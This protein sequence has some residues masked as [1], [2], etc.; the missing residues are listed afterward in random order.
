MS[1]LKVPG[2]EHFTLFAFIFPITESYRIRER[3]VLPTRESHPNSERNNQ[4]VTYMTQADLRQAYDNILENAVTEW[5]HRKGI[6]LRN[7]GESGS[8]SREMLAPS[9]QQQQH[10]QQQQQ[11]RP[12]IH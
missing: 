3:M 1:T 6:L 7:P 11:Q 12:I 5:L 4:N 10:H 9:L 2:D 8:G